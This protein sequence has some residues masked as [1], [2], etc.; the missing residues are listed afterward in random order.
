MNQYITENHYRSFPF[1]QGYTNNFSDAL[2]VD[3]QVVLATD[4]QLYVDG[5]VA[6]SSTIS[7]AGGATL[8]FTIHSTALS[9]YKLVGDV[10]DSADDTR[11]LLTLV[12]A[13]DVPHPE[14]GYGFVVVG[15]M[16]SLISYGKGIPFTPVPLD[17]AITRVFATNQPLSIFV[18]NKTRP[19]PSLF[20]ETIGAASSFDLQARIAETVEGCIEVTTEPDVD[21]V[22]VDDVGNATEIAIPAPDSSYDQF[23]DGTITTVTIHDID[24]LDAIPTL[25]TAYDAVVEGG[26]ACA[27][28]CVVGPG[29]NVVL[30]G[31]LEAQTLKFTYQLGG[32]L[33]VNC[34]SVPGYPVLG[35]VASD[36]VKAINGTHTHNGVLT[37]KGGTGVSLVQDPA[38]HRILVLVNASDLTRAAP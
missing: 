32:G 16:A 12:D 27:P 36:C 25:P 21:Q 24:I 26:V 8:V 9:G 14:L 34:D 37:L 15:N 33:G 10:L 35:T 20:G 31:D 18:G 29:Y 7:I 23:S 17:P 22:S 4:F 38:G 30:S 3:A 13:S 2:I 19:G 6:F 5:Y 1:L 11:I 28:G